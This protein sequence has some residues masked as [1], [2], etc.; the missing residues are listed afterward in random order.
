MLQVVAVLALLLP[1][2]ALAAPMGPTG[3]GGPTGDDRAPT[4]FYIVHLNAEP[5]ANYNGYLP[6]LQATAR[7]ATGRK[8]DPSAPESQLYRAYLDA[9]EEAALRRIGA[10]EARIVYRYRTAFPG[11]AARL[12]AEQSARLGAAPEVYKVSP[13]KLARLDQALPVT[14]PKAVLGV[15]GANFLGLPDGLWKKLG[16]VD[17]AGEGVI[18]GLLD[19]GITPGHPSFADAPATSAGKQNYFGPAYTPPRLWYGACQ[20][21]EGFPA[22]SCNNKLVGA[23]YYV[24]GFGEENLNAKEFLSPRDAVGHGTHLASIAAGNFGVDPVIGGNDL[25][26]DLISGIAPR[27]YIASYKVCW[28]GRPDPEQQLPPEAGCATSDSLAAIDAAVEDGVDVINYS[29]GSGTAGFIGPVEAAF[30]LAV[31]AGVFVANSAGNLGPDPESVGSPTAVPWITSVA[32]S[33]LPRAFEAAATVS[34]KSGQPPSPLTVEGRSLTASLAEVPLVDSAALPAPGFTPDQAELCF[35]GSLDR[36]AVAGKAVLCKRGTNPR[37]EKSMV[38]KEAGGLGMILYNQEEPQELVADLHW[39]PAVHIGH[40]DGLAVKSL[41]STAGQPVVSIVGGRAAPARGD[42]LADFSS[43]GPQTAVPDIPKPDLSAPGISIIGANAPT[44]I[45]GPAPEVPGQLFALASGTSMSS[46]H[47]AGAAA[48]LTQLHPSWSPAALKSALMTSANPRMFKEDGVTPADPFDMGSGRID[49]NRAADPGLMLEAGLNDY[50]QYLEGIDPILIPGDLEPLR[51]VDL[52]LPAIS[53]S[54]LAGSDF[55]R[56]TFVSVEPTMSIWHV[57]VEGLDGIKTAISPQI[58]VARP[59]Q[60]QTI[61]FSF[62]VDGAAYYA[63]TFGAI[64]ATNRLTGRT[65]RLPVSIKPVK[66]ISAKSVF[67]STDEASGE[68][69]ISATTG[70]KGKLSAL[71]WGLGSA[72][73]SARK[74]I[75]TTDGRPSPVPGPSVDVFDVKV[76]EVQVL[77]GEIS[78]VDGGNPFTDLDL[79]LYYDDGR[80]G[81]DDEDLIEFSASVFPTEAISVARPKPGRYRFAVVGFSTQFPESVYDF[82]SWLVT[83][84]TPDDPANA[85]AIVVTGDPMS[86][87]IG[88][89]ARLR[90]SWSGVKADGTYYGL[91]TY[92]DS[93]TPDPQSRPAAHTVVRLAK[94]LPVSLGVAPAAVAPGGEA[95]AR[96]GEKARAAKPGLPLPT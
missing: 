15:E 10:S 82:S 90:L 24:R 65:V 51:P 86:V 62:T 68:I 64:V 67:V 30:L 79:Y 44:L 32:A 78:N 37:V 17:H 69:R 19:T 91:V 22:S 36:A 29:V 25:G 48:L 18:V 1:P 55:T 35:P 40:A 11:F 71:G 13:D 45:E 63:Y 75:T 34:S 60:S 39:V 53:F 38:V 5:L 3:P 42:V 61:D 70:F 85:P 28:A 95:P 83:D 54:G 31:D 74:R 12:T 72:K 96:P 23:R 52:N 49:P 80:D 58:F 7:K 20:A 56:R 84:P 77:A 6:G 21:G 26:V 43:R 59:G 87:T 57:G 94:G 93:A 14:D 46:P 88:T 92:H 16:G 89:S 4:A 73:T 66:V 9:L 27:A 50:L 81:F 33:T 2:G 47:A 76:E 8:L 41:I